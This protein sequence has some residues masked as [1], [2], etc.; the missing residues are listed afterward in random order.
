MYDTVSMSMIQVPKN[1]HLHVESSSQWVALGL[2]LSQWA[3][4]GLESQPIMRAFY[5][6]AFMLP[7]NHLEQIMSSKCASA[8]RPC[9]SAAAAEC[10]TGSSVLE[11]LE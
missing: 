10:D 9:L 11:Y 3:A 5:P 7:T 2:S 4:T 8:M 1:L 6:M